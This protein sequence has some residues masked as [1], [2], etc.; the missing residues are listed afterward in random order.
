LPLFSRS[1]EAIKVS[2]KDQGMINVAKRKKRA[3]MAV[4]I[5]KKCVCH[6]VKI[7][8]TPGLKLEEPISMTV[9]ST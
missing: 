9:V 8:M 6:S 7:H 2:L 3:I 1:R 5:R 4:C